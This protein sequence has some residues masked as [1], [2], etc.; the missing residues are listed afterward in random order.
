VLDVNLPDF[1]GFELCRRLKA[2]PFTAHIPVIHLS[3]SS[4]DD[5]ARVRGLDGGADAYLTDPIHASV[6]VATVRALLRMREAEDALR[7]AAV[8]AERVSELNG[9]MAVA[10]SER[11]VV[12]AL[13]D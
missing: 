5:E 3:Q 11:Q 10:Q 7:Q 2:D 4:V 8:D 1:S 6:L 12:T 9:R 13:L